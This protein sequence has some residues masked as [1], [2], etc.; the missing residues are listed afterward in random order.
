[1]RSEPKGRD[2]RT[3]PEII[4]KWGECTNSEK[5]CVGLILFSPSLYARL[6]YDLYIGLLKQDLIP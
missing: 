5:Y 1:M 2:L 4:K 6:K 3:Q